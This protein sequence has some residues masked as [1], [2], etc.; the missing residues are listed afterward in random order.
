MVGWVDE[1]HCA[2]SGPPVMNPIFYNL[3]VGYDVGGCDKIFLDWLMKY[4]LFVHP[5]NSKTFLSACNRNKQHIE[6]YNTKC[7]CENHDPKTIP[8]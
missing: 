2:M 8:F 5:I 6:I 7:M 4:F 1:N 3:A